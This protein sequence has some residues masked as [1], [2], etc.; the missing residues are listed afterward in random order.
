MYQGLWATLKY[1]TPTWNIW[2]C[3]WGV[4]RVTCIQ[5]MPSLIAIW[6]LF[7]ASENSKVSFTRAKFWYRFLSKALTPNENMH[8]FSH[9]CNR[10]SDQVWW[11]SP[12]PFTTG[13]ATSYTALWYCVARLGYQF[14]H[15]TNSPNEISSSRQT[16]RLEKK[17]TLNFF[18]TYIEYM[19]WCM[20]CDMHISASEQAQQNFLHTCIVVTD[21]LTK[22]HGN[23]TSRLEPPKRPRIP[24]FDIVSRGWVINLTA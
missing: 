18:H 20:W 22:F 7:S 8:S 21:S 15:V 12:Q 23:P 24:L 16:R 4:A 13:Q 19:I 1:F 11:E 10:Y 14:K 6:L 2:C 5:H 3:V 9:R 17:N